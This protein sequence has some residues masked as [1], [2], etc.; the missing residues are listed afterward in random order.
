[1]AKNIME[2]RSPRG[3][4]PVSKTVVQMLTTSLEEVEESANQL[5]KVIT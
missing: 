3:V 2:G 1:V 5:T 4:V